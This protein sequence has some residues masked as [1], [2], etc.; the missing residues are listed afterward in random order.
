MNLILTRCLINVALGQ[1]VKL[2]RKRKK[3]PSLSDAESCFSLSLSLSGTEFCFSF[4]FPLSMCLILQ[5]FIP[6]NLI[7]Q[8]FNKKYPFKEDF[9]SCN[10]YKPNLQT[11]LK[12]VHLRLFVSAQYF[13]NFHCYRFDFVQRKIVFSLQ[14]VIVIFEII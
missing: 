6:V 2:N 13:S 9:F 7:H 3:S 4:T 5:I 8:N 10:I 14:L 12:A 1:T 11:Q